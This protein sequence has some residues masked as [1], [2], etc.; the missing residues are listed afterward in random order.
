MSENS[1]QPYAIQDRENGRIGV[2]RQIDSEE[3][4]FEILFWVSD[5]MVQVAADHIA[6][7]RTQR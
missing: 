1:G 7:R 6:A 4:N 5:E 2:A 3:Q